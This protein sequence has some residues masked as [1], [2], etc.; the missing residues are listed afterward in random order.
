MISGITTI[1]FDID[2]ALIKHSS[3]LEDK[4]LRLRGFEPSEEFNEQVIHFWNNLYKKLQNGQKV[5]KSKVYSIAEKMIPFLRKMDLSGEEWF[6]L[7]NKID[8]PQ[9]IDGAYEI[10]GYLQ[11]NGYYIVA[12]TNAFASDQAQ[13]LRKLNILNFFEKIYGWDTVPSVKPQCKAL[14]SLIDMYSTDSIILIGDVVHT[15]IKFANKVG[16]KSIGYNLQYGERDHCIEPT[17][18]IS[19]LLEIKKYL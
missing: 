7:L 11:R 18:A 4:V 5:E 6:E 19:Q 12:F 17:I 13:I 10:L 3:N 8:D 16:I 1:C 14:D 15:D 9:L 2:W